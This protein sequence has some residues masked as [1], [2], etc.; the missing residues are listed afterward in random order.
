MNM[1]Q[2]LE[3]GLRDLNKWALELLREKTL[4]R[5]FYLSRL[6]EYAEYSRNEYGCVSQ[7]N[8]LYKNLENRQLYH[9]YHTDLLISLPQCKNIPYDIYL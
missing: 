7:T 6:L 2:L 4:W 1:Q 8:S 5:C 9:L 3:S